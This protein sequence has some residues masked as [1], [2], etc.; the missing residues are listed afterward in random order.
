MQSLVSTAALYAGM[1]WNLMSS[2]RAYAHVYRWDLRMGQRGIIDRIPWA[3][4]GPV[5]SLDWCNPAESEGG[6]LASGSLDATV[7][8]SLFSTFK[9]MD[10]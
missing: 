10:G 7:K 2:S 4:T 8:V 5:M 6:W 9:P 1:S 3:H